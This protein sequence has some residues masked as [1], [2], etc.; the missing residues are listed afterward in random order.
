[1]SEFDSQLRG[2]PTEFVRSR[3]RTTTIVWTVA[4]TICAVSAIAAILNYTALQDIGAG[5]EGRRDGLRGLVAPGV[6][7]LLV[8][9]AAYGGWSLAAWSYKWRR[10]QTGTV[11]KQTFTGRVVGGLP[12][13]QEIAARF[14]SGDP[15]VYLP[16]RSGQRGDVWIGAFTADDDECGYV[17]VTVGRGRSA[18]ALPL[19]TLHG[20][21]Y[22]GMRLLRQ[23][24]FLSSAPQAAIKGF[25]DP[26]LRN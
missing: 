5:Y 4:T 6:V 24:D 25:L 9:G 22:H 15:R 10:V 11:V 13:A 21:G 14:A 16:V 8:L 23:D 1:M 26:T 7:V 2:A 17:T 20:Q 3:S 18:K 19:I 12:A